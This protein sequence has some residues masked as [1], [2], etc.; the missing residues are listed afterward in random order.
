VS[1]TPQHVLRFAASLDGFEDGAGTLRQLLDE[2]GITGRPRYHVELAFEEVAVNI[3]RHAHP[4]GDIE[5]AVAF[6]DGVTVLTFE[7]NGPPFDPRRF[8]PPPVAES[9]EE[10]R[11]GGLGLVLVRQIASRLDYERT[12]H[13]RNRL[14]LAIAPRQDV[15]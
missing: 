4:S 1:S 15:A 14:T 10:A 11:V 5:V 8:P 13:Q 3:V 6:E 7:D 9:L 12:P 2:H